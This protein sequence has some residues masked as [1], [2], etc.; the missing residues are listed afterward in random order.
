M[1]TKAEILKSRP[2]FHAQFGDSFEVYTEFHGIC[3]SKKEFLDKHPTCEWQI[4]RIAEAKKVLPQ[5]KGEKILFAYYSYEDYSGTAYVL[6]SK[7]GKLYHVFGGHCSCYGLEDQWN[8]EEVNL[9]ALA[10][11][12]SDGGRYDY[13]QYRKELRKFLRI[14]ETVNEDANIL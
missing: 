12:L 4:E 5:H 9:K 13:K 1:K 14:K 8:P 10:L 6:F 7:K 11:A 2:Q 3:L